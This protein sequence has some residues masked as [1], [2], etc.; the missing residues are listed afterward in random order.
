MPVLFRSDSVLDDW[1]LALPYLEEAA[2][3]GGGCRDWTLEDLR[4]R[5]DAGRLSLWLMTEE[6]EVIGAGVTTLVSYPRRRVLEVLLFGCDPHT[7]FATVLPDL[8]RYADSMGASILQGTGRPGWARKLK[9]RER[10][11]WELEV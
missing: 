10:T 8:K 11:V 7:G 6:A 9:A 3:K 5:A 4:V 2:K 1:R